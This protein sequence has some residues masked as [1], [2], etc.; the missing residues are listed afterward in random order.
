VSLGLT[1][2]LAAQMLLHSGV[3]QAQTALPYKPTKRG[4]G[5]T[6]RLLW[7]QGPV[8]LS[9][10]WATGTKE[11]EGCR[12]FYEPLG[13]WDADATWCPCSPPR[14]PRAT[15]VA[16]RPTADGDLEAQARRHLARRPAFTADDVVFTW[17]FCKDPASSTTTVATYKDIQVDKVDSHT[18][19]VTFPRPT[20]F[21][22]S[23]S[24]APW[25]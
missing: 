15:T 6:L 20:P 8:H 5:G 12:I 9:P 4:G 18:V 1:A 22:P 3:A 13:A 14:F 10:H 2:P 7:W 23:P 21:W 19:R 25:A 16:C 11:Q 17:E 24:S